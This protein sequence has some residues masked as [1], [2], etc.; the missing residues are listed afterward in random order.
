MPSARSVPGLVAGIFMVSAGLLYALGGC[1]AAPTSRGSL[2][3]GTPSPHAAYGDRV[4]AA[5]DRLPTGALTYNKPNAMRV[6]KMQVIEAVVSRKATA[7]IEHDLRKNGSTVNSSVTVSS[8]MK[9]HLYGDPARVNIVAQ[10]DDSVEET[11]DPGG[12]MMWQWYVTPTRSG[13]TDLNLAIDVGVEVPPSPERHFRT[14]KSV[15][16]PIASNWS[17]E[18]PQ[19]V[20]GNWQWLLSTLLIPLGVW[21]VG[22]VRGRG[23][24]RPA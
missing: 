2:A 7:S 21:L 14:V 5:I 17:Y 11:F 15:H 9:A 18:F 22:V 10:Q 16:I 4:Q 24:G 3:P 8:F 19:F 23:R 12:R 1:T 6:G 20:F 13:P